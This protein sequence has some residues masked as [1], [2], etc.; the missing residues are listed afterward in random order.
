MSY[1]GYRTIYLPS[2][3]EADKRGFVPEHRVV[4]RKILGRPLKPGEVVHHKDQNRLNNSEDNIIVFVSRE[5]HTRYHQGGTLVE[6]DE[7]NVYTSYFYRPEIPCAYCGQMFKPKRA[8]AKF[9]C[10]E[11]SSLAQRKTDRPNRRE[12][13]RL[14]FE[15]NITQISNMY[16]LTDNGIRRWCQ[17]EKLPY[18]KKDLDKMREKERLKAEEKA[19]EKEMKERIAERDRMIKKNSK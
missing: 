12:L 14:L 19:L 3:P 17:A 7:P 1:S 5:A 2:D 18:K 6:T 15:Y 16:G 11:C 10:S 8:D 4:A 13:K 9:C